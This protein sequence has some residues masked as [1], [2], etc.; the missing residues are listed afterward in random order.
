MIWQR[1]LFAGERIDPRRHLLGLR[2]I[3]DEDD[4]R[5]RATHVPEHERRDGRP[6]RAAGHVT[7]ILDR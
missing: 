6:D 2:A 7:E 4:G 1:D 3:V 5:P